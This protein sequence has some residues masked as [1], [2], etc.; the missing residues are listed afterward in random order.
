M[1]PSETGSYNAPDA[2][3][4]TKFGKLMIACEDLREHPVF[5]AQVSSFSGGETRNLGRKNRML[6]QARQMKAK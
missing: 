1:S 5:S 2:R 6:S 4:S 3:S